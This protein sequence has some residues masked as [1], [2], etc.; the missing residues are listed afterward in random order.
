M[1]LLLNDE[2]DFSLPTAQEITLVLEA[3]WQE[4]RTKTKYTFLITSQWARVGGRVCV[5]LQGKVGRMLKRSSEP[6]PVMRAVA[7]SL[8]TVRRAS[9]PLS[10]NVPRSQ[11]QTLC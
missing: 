10:F 5:R 7:Q 6:H 4:P 8:R 2:M 1:Q 11:Y 9:R 3:L